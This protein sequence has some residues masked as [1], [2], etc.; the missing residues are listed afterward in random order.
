MMLMVILMRI[1]VWISV[2]ADTQLNANIDCNETDAFP[3]LI[4]PACACA[5]NNI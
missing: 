5:Y 4:E 2:D 3:F 1:L